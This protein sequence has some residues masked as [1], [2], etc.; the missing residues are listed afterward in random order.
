VESH[1]EELARGREKIII[2]NLSRSGL[3]FCQTVAVAG[4][5]AKTWEK[6]IYFSPVQFF[7]LFIFNW[8]LNLTTAFTAF[9]YNSCIRP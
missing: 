6:C 7:N 4:F 9:L 3:V 5:A 1:E 8:C 2:I